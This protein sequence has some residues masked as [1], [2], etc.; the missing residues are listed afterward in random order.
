[1]VDLPTADSLST[2][3]N[4]HE[5]TFFLSSA[6]IPFRLLKETNACWHAMGINLRLASNLFS[7]KETKERNAFT[8]NNYLLAERRREAANK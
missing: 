8:S 6:C 5:S 3:D 7:F 2:I 4:G 1:M